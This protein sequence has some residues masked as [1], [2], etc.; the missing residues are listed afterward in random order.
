MLTKGTIHTML[1]PLVWCGPWLGIELGTSHTLSQH[2]TASFFEAVNVYQPCFAFKR[3][4]IPYMFLIRLNCTLVRGHEED[5]FIRTKTASNCCKRTLWK[6]N[7]Y[8]YLTYTTI[9]G[10][11]FHHKKQNNAQTHPKIKL[12]CNYLKHNH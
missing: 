10:N 6:E 3:P 2:S 5:T 7:E 8:W 11:S 9:T 12:G 1:S 4:Y